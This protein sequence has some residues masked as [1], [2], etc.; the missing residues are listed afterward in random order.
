[1][2]IRQF[3][4]AVTL[5]ASASFF[6]YL[7]GC[8]GAEGVDTG[9]S[10]HTTVVVRH[11]RTGG[12]APAAGGGQTTPQAGGK[13][14]EA[15]VTGGVGTFKG[16]VVFVGTPPA[17]APLMA[18]GQ[19]K[20][21]LCAKESIPDQK[22]EVDPSGGVANVVIFLPKAPAGAAVPPPPTEPVEFDNKN[23]HF[24]PHLA[25]MR[26]GQLVKVLN[27]D[28][29]LQHN[30]HTLP[31]RT[32]GFN[33]TIPKEGKEFTYTKPEPEPCEVK[34]DIH[35]WMHG[36][37][38]PLDHPYVA[39]TGS[40]GEFEIKNL[41]AGEHTFRV[42]AEGAVGHYLDRGLKV[43]IEPGKTTTKEI[44]YEAANFA[45]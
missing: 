41:P 35:S 4:F 26:V 13:T 22:L 44:K 45:G 11:E 6:T 18:K 37:H 14:G 21:P 25:V 27:D 17:L 28:L 42:W 2:R 32:A 31:Q 8:N 39:V 16:K 12:G 40:N 3:G 9:A 23:C 30:T 33:S 36:W 43:T 7:S 19:A 24:V 20:D 15:P 34:C 1:M 38:F 10:T 5:A 29:P